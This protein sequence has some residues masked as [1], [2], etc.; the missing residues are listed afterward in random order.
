MKIHWVQHVP[1]GS[2][3]RI[4]DW[5]Q[6]RNHE[7][8][9]VR[10]FA[11]QDVPAPGGCDALVVM[12][13]PMSA[14]DRGRPRWLASEIAAVRAVAAHGIPVLGVCLGAQVLAAAH[15]ATVLRAPQR[16]I[17][18]FPVA[19]RAP[20]SWSGGVAAADDVPRT[21]TRVLA[22]ALA[23]ALPVEFT[24]LHWHGDTYI[25]PNGAIVVA[26]SAA[27]KNQIVVFGPRAAGLQFHLEMAAD[28]V[29]ALVEN[30]GDEI[31]GG[32]WARP[33]GEILAGAESHLH[34]CHQILDSLLDAFF[35]PSLNNPA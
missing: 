8:V 13:G 12:G 10:A 11:G 26:S 17:G 23:D 7:L 27:C 2:I 21:G 4:A 30:C 1:L 28:G 34:A 18:W 25:R 15:G 29:A 31:D 33:V 6:A 3:G 32:P 20:V 35:D 16:E 14:G 19:V 24:P 9:P 22:R 5:A